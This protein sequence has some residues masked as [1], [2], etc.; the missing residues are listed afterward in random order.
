MSTLLLAKAKSLRSTTHRTSREALATIRAQAERTYRSLDPQ[1]KADE[2]ATL[3][4]FLGL[5]RLFYA[6]VE[7]YNARVKLWTFELDKKVLRLQTPQQLIAAYKTFEAEV[8]HRCSFQRHLQAAVEKENKR[9]DEFL[10]T[11]VPSVPPQLRPK[12]KADASRMPVE[13]QEPQGYTPSFR[14]EK[15][16]RSPEEVLQDENN[17][18]RAQ[19]EMLKKD[20]EDRKLQISNLKEE[21]S[22]LN[23]TDN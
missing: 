6:I 15:L 10:E 13:L 21:I 17:A 12:P 16:E 7:F 4:L 22:V 23:G 11:V 20:L 9:W 19:I 2:E 14:E 3:A 1:N 5:D 8:V 18:L